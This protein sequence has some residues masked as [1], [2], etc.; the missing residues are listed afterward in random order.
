VP[1]MIPFHDGDAE[2]DN[3]RSRGKPHDARS[4]KARRL[5][6][7]PA[8]YSGPRGGPAPA[9]GPGPCYDVNVTSMTVA[10]LAVATVNA[11]LAEVGVYPPSAQTV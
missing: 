4:P 7:K 5:T 9:A 10:P 3:V 6:G 2:D 11:P 1:P 8:Q